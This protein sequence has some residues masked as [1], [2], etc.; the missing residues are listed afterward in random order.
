MGNTEEMEEITI[1]ITPDKKREF[2]WEIQRQCSPFTATGEYL[3]YICLL[4]GI[5]ENIIMANNDDDEKLRYILLGKIQGL[6]KQKENNENE[7]N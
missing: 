4:W 5:S 7:K 6:W 2:I 1:E 3:Q